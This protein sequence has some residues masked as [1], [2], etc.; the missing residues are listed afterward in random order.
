MLIVAV[1][2]G[3]AVAWRYYERRQAEEQQRIARAGQ[4]KALAALETTLGKW[5]DAAKLAGSTPRVALAQPVASLQSLKREAEG[6]PVPSCLD[7]AKQ[8][9]VAG[10]QLV[11]DG[12]IKFMANDYALSDVKPEDLFTAAGERFKAY[13]EEKKRCSS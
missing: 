13:H 10:M 12:F 7:P 11:V 8:Q 9:Q 4:Q 6:I 5:V 3:G 2:L 1:A